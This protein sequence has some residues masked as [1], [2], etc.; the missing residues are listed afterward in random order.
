MNFLTPPPPGWL[1]TQTSQ[2]PQPL[3][4]GQRLPEVAVRKFRTFTREELRAVGIEVAPCD[5]TRKIKA[6]IDPND[7]DDGD[8]LILSTDGVKSLYLTV[9]EAQTFNLPGLP[10]FPVP[11]RSTPTKVEYNAGEGWRAAP[12]ELLATPEEAERM[13]ADL[14]SEWSIE[15]ASQGGKVS[16]RIPPEEPRRP[17][18]I[19]GHG[20]S[21][22]VGTLYQEQFVKFAKGAPGR[23]TFGE[24]LGVVFLKD[25]LAVS[26]PLGVVPVPV[27][28]P[29][30]TVVESAGPIGDALQV[31]LPEKPTG[32][33]GDVVTLLH[34]VLAGQEEIKALLTEEAIPWV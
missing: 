19:R 3:L 20:F 15:D 24:S 7:K 13:V 16:F 11:N 5:P 25:V 4:P 26:S 33:S 10:I 17:F 8:F 21:A 14:G 34:K 28:V 29:E 12:P 1:E 9:R 23:W 22:N 6:W 32:G 18:V 27:E 31:Y 30:G 2:S